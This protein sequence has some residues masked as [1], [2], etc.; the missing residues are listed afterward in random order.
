MA[1]RPKTL[2]AAL[3]P[4]ILGGSIAVADNRFTV[5]PTL[6]ALAG[7]LLLQIGSNLAND[8]FDYFKGADTPDR[9][10]PTRVTA[11]GL[12]TPAQVRAGIA[13]VFGLAVLVGVYLVWV[14][15]WPIL[16]VGIAAIVAALAYTGGPKPFGYLGLGDPAVFIFFGPIA[17][18]G[19]YYVQALTVT[20]ALAVASLP[21][22]AL[23]TNI[24]VVNN[25]RDIETDRR[26]GKITLAVRFGRTGARMEYGFL[27]A[28]AYTTP[29]LLWLGGG[30]AW[31]LLPLITLPAALRLARTIQH[32]DDGPTLN[33]ALAGSAR[34]ALLYALA[35]SVSFLLRADLA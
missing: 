28:I 9:R 27:L 16:T 17:V 30:S 5:G 34:L 14:G 11:A 32:A 21:L 13:V 4:V 26:A 2:P 19:T 23:I 18:C 3:A 35:L 10:G 25:L 31:M 1:A 15:G 12:L 6:A 7:A 20:P 24:L 8:Y 22:G 33:S 29:F